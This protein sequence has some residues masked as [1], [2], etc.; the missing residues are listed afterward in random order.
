MVYASGGVP[1]RDGAHG[2][3]VLVVHRPL[4]GD[5]T[6]PKGKREPGE[7]DEEC[8]IREVEEE[9]GLRCAL[10]HELPSTSYVD[11]HAD[12][13]V[14]LGLRRRRRGDR[15]DAQAGGQ[16]GG[17]EITGQAHGVL[18]DIRDIAD[19]GRTCADGGE[20]VFNPTGMRGGHA[21]AVQPRE[22]AASSRIADG[23]SARPAMLRMRS[24]P[25][26]TSPSASC[27]QVT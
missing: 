27:A 8:A 15:R 11:Q 21:T 17:S 16:D 12:Q 14:R 1:V 19:S 18:L 4:Y 13:V 22:R 5:W 2:L 9:T 20:R 7:T 6:F 3:E 26:R 10:E 24:P 25:L 23:S